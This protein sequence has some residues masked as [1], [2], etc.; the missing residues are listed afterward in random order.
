[1]RQFFRTT[2]FNGFCKLFR[3]YFFS[4]FIAKLKIVWPCASAS[5]YYRRLEKI[6]Q[7]GGIIISRHQSMVIPPDA[8]EKWANNRIRHELDPNP[9]YQT[10][11]LC[12]SKRNW[13]ISL[14]ASII[15]R[16]CDWFISRLNTDHISRLS[17]QN[18]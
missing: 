15:G 13:L 4:C 5:Y 9:S 10:S 1:M 14:H 2:I 16:W 12:V 6:S 11:M 7:E 3:Q 8:M 17:R 18:D